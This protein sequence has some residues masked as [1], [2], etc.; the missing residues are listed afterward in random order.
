M[1][2]F[3]SL[4]LAG[5]VLGT[6]A[7]AHS[8]GE[9]RHDRSHVTIGRQL[10]PVPS[11]DEPEKLIRYLRQQ[12]A[13]LQKE[14]DELRAQVHELEQQIGRLT[15]GRVAPGSQVP[16]TTD[17]GMMIPIYYQYGL[18]VRGRRPLDDEKPHD[19]FR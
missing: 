12:N 5:A 6:I 16:N 11:E 4:I 8:M 9:P 3:P 18:P 17:P 7:S 2:A 13:V 1:K 19:R 14:R 10:R 15:N